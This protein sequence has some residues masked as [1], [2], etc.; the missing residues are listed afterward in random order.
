MHRRSRAW[1]AEGSRSRQLVTHIGFVSTP[2]CCSRKH[3]PR[4]FDT[5]SICDQIRQG[6][7]TGALIGGASVF[8]DAALLVEVDRAASRPACGQACSL[9]RPR[10]AMMPRYFRSTTSPA[11]RRCTPSPTGSPT[12]R[13]RCSRRWP[14]R[15]G[16]HLLRAA[17]VTRLVAAGL[18]EHDEWAEGR[19][20]SDASS[21]NNLDS[22]STSNLENKPES[23]AGAAALDRRVQPRI[24]W[25]GPDNPPPSWTCALSVP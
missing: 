13:P 2:T 10:P 1:V 15:R 8:G 6:N 9:R 22:A 3:E 20:T 18:A 25:R 14:T 17:P 23:E 7:Q 19:R 24:K 11:P 12:R 16:L 4:D 5:S 21:S